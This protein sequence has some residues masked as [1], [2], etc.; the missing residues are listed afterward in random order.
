MHTKYFDKRADP[1]VPAVFICA[2][3]SFFRLALCWCRR[4]SGLGKDF[5]Q[6][7]MIR[8]GSPLCAH[9]LV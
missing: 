7:G 2:V 9:G 1:A 6:T 3:M 4:F 8:G 5:T